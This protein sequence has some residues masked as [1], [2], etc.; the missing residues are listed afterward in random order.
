MADIADHTLKGITWAESLGGWKSLPETDLFEVEYWELE[1]AK[2]KKS[3]ESPKFE[4]KV[5][6]PV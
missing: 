5:I 6:L 4:G 3:A 2:L 1:Q